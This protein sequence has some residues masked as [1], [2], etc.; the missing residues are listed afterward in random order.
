VGDEE[1]NLQ[2]FAYGYGY[3]KALI[4]AVATEGKPAVATG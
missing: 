1:L 4:Q 3:I 2:V